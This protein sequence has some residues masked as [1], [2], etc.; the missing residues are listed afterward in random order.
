MTGYS[1]DV[2]V[3]T[4]DCLRHLHALTQTCQHASV[5]M[6]VV[7]TSPWNALFLFFWGLLCHDLC[8]LVEI[9]ENQEKSTTCIEETEPSFVDLQMVHQYLY[10]FLSLYAMSNSIW[11]AW[12]SYFFFNWYDYLFTALYFSFVTLGYWWRNWSW[13]QHFESS[14]WSSQCSQILWHVLQ[15]RCEKWRPALACSWGK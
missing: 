7:L 3:L 9:G 15:E 11:I 13:V 2:G 8:V 5:R 10:V 4:G 1:L 14:L 12:V 6:W